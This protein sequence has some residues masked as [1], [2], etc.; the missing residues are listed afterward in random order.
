MSRLCEA[1]ENNDYD[2]VFHLLKGGH[3]I[4][5][6]R[7]LIFPQN[8][9]A[10]KK[11]QD[12]VDSLFYEYVITNQFNKAG[13][14]LEWAANRNRQDENGETLY[15]QVTRE[16]NHEACNYMKSIRANPYIC[17]DENKTVFDVER[18][19]IDAF[20]DAGLELDIDTIKQMLADDI[21]PDV[22][23]LNGR[24]L[25]H[26]LCT[27][28]ISDSQHEK[29]NRVLDLLLESGADP[30]TVDNDGEKPPYYTAYNAVK[31]STIYTQYE[32]E[33]HLTRSGQN[34]E[35]ILW[36][37]ML[38]PFEHVTNN[39]IKQVREVYDSDLN[40]DI[41]NYRGQT[42]FHMASLY[43]RE[44]TSYIDMMVMLLDLGSNPT[45]LDDEGYNSVWGTTRKAISRSK[46]MAYTDSTVVI[47]STTLKRL[48]KTYGMYLEWLIKHSKYTE[49]K[50]SLTPSN[51]NSRNDNG[52]TLLHYSTWI[53]I[54]KNKS[55]ESISVVRLLLQNNAR[56][57]TIDRFNNTPFK[58]ILRIARH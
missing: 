7:G 42:A 14:M 30:C 35:A 36:W 41:R 54:K 16:Q 51:I 45:L 11:M 21:H 9:P 2:S 37:Y 57:G 40:P 27:I 50:Q 10:N 34:G 1:F 13:R 48:L 44:D 43:A 53:A 6:L 25:F 15:H 39:D 28:S 32:N 31:R 29:I 17:S 58:E 12:I 24:T 4:N 23:N 3:D 55:P 22:R 46:W 33:Y 26:V 38:L 5:E 8:V 47:G 20:H 18:E 56:V 49:L 52:Q 19:P